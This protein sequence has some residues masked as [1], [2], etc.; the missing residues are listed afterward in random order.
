MYHIFDGESRVLVA[1]NEVTVGGFL[2]PLMLII[3]GS[4]EAYVIGDGGEI[5][6]DKELWSNRLT[7][8]FENMM[9]HTVYVKPNPDREVKMIIKVEEV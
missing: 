2:E 9:N 6:T 5:S 7:L 3:Q 4:G 8:N 1:Q